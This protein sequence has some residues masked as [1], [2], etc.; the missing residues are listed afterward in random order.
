MLGSSR[1]QEY[2][3]A[4]EMRPNLNSERMELGIRYETMV[5][6]K[7]KKEDMLRLR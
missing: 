5:N 2:T 1:G 6:E 4:E 7:I 3:L